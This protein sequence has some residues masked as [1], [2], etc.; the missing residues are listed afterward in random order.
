MDFVYSKLVT[1]LTQQLQG[2]KR[3]FSFFA[4]LLSQP[5]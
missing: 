4:F 5:L 3:G 2:K 1:M